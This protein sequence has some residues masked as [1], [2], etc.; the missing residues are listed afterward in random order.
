LAAPT[1]NENKFRKD[2]SILL[3]VSAIFFNQYQSTAIQ[4]DLDYS[5][6][7]DEDSIE[8]IELLIKSS[9]KY[10]EWYLNLCALAHFINNKRY[11]KNYRQINNHTTSTVTNNLF[12]IKGIEII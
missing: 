4:M 3:I 1:T 7:S 2:K 12:S 10:H 11:F 6:I 9:D 5:D 8:V